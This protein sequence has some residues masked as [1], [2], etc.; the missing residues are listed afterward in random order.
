MINFTELT[1]HD[2]SLFC[3][4]NNISLVNL[5]H[6]SGG[7]C[8]SLLDNKSGTFYTNYSWDSSSALEKSIKDLLA[9][10]ALGFDEE[11]KTQPQHIIQS[12]KTVNE[13]KP[14]KLEMRTAPNL[15]IPISEINIPKVLSK[16]EVNGVYSIKNED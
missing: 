4:Q 16:K 14:V 8:I 2:L 13:I 3:K 7:C 12:K 5:S 11:E 15:G 6:G 1:F 9:D 10:R